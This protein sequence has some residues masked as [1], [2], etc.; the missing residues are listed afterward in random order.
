MTTS[1]FPNWFA[2]GALTC[3]MGLGLSRALML[4]MHGVS[5]IVLDRQR[6]ALQMVTDTLLITC[7]VAFAYEIITTTGNINFYIRPSLLDQPV[8]VGLT[9]QLLGTLLVS[10]AVILYAI[11]LRDL[12]ESWRWGLDRSAPGPLVTKGIY[13]RIRHPIYFA[14]DLWLI[15]T[16]FLLGRL[17]FLVLTLIWVPLLH[18]IMV[19]EEQFLEGLFSDAYRDYSK[20]VRRYLFW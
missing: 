3:L 20:K 9:S 7:L 11:S 10:A 14:L 12:G 16:F 17:S 5:V 13:S 4:R 8:V 6:T 1:Q 2:L 19:R 15:G 18:K